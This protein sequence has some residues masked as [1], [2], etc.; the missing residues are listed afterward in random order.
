[1][2]DLYRMYGDNWATTPSLK[3]KDTILRPTGEFKA[4]QNILDELHQLIDNV[5]LGKDAVADFLMRE[6]AHVVYGSNNEARKIL[7]LDET[8]KIC[9][10][11]F[12]G[13]KDVEYSPR[14]IIYCSE[15]VKHFT[16]ALIDPRSIR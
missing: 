16:N 3:E 15:V 1:M 9:Q 12:E 10:A 6:M 13:H 5:K 14:S 11:I 7:G 8:L 4:V 2:S